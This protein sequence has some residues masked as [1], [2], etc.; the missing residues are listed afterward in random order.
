MLNYIILHATSVDKLQ[1]LV[2]EFM[3][4]GRWQCV[5]GMTIEQFHTP[6]SDTYYQTVVLKEVD[7]VHTTGPR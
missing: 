7:C 2:N 5:G 3:K 6:F 4:N 1:D